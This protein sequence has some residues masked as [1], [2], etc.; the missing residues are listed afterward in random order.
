[1]KHLDRTFPHTKSLVL[2]DFDTLHNIFTQEGNKLINI[3]R[4]TGAPIVSW[5]LKRAHEKKDFPDYLVERGE[6]DIFFPTN[7]RFMR[8]LH[9]KVY[10]KSSKVMRAF[11]FTEEFARE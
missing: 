11:E 6:A 8:Y 10:K 3:F 2:A 9:K 1:M 5:K 7:F 4:G